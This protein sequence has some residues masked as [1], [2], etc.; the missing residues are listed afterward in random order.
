MS[1][2]SPDE[3][4]I[5]GIAQNSAGD[6]FVAGYVSDQ[7]VIACFDNDGVA[8]WS[9]VFGDAETTILMALALMPGGDVVATGVEVDKNRQAKALVARVSN[10]GTLEWSK[11]FGGVGYS[12]LMS[13]A[14]TKTELVVV[15][16]TNS[17]DG[18]FGSKN[19][20]STFNAVLVRM[21]DDGTI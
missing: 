8:K 18:E 10:D 21:T 1:L 19:L 12:A 20:T 7:A 13:I 17:V 14:E 3:G 6:V 2:G 4:A 16:F 11:T 15:G 9:N 5:I